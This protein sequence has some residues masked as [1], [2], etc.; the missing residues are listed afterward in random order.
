MTNGVVRI[1][2]AT[3]IDSS[4]AAHSG[5]PRL[6]IAKRIGT[7]HRTNPRVAA[8]DSAKPGAN[9]ISGHH[10]NTTTT[11]AP[12]AGNACERREESPAANPTPPITAARNTLSVGRTRITKPTTATTPTTNTVRGRPPPARTHRSTAP[13]AR[14]R[15]APDTATR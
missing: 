15:F 10:S 1:C 4:A 5:T 6:V 12:S 9:A 7:D 13:T 2:A 11:A 14:T 3:V 8:T